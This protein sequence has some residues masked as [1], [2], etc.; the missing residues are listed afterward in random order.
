MSTV[1]V[2][3]KNLELSFTHDRNCASRGISTETLIRKAVEKYKIVKD[4]NFTVWTGDV[5]NPDFFS[6][7]VKEDSYDR[8]FPCFI[9]D[10]FSE[11]GMG[12]YDQTIQSFV[13]TIPLTNKIGW[14][15]AVN[16]T[17]RQIY[18]D[19]FKDTV[20]SE[21]VCN[22]WNRINPR[23]LT[24]HT[25]TY[26]SYQDQIDRWKYLLDMEGCGYSGRTKVLLNTPR[27]VF[28][29][30][31]PH[32]EWWHQYIKPWVH[33]VP[34]KRDLSDLEENY[35]RIESDEKL[36]QHIKHNQSEFAKQFL[37]RDSALLRIK[38]IIDA[39]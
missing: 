9:Y 11:T 26:L 33:Y 39:L 15:G 16:C 5:Y 14:I 10:K 6:V 36:Q 18:L 37:V 21:A 34:V 29:A 28:I 35:H 4:F 12:D 17:A 13:A 38:D 3:Q 27:I 2:T 25:P 1:S 8:G 19:K 22:Q 24:Q 20:F 30:D 32:K 31:R 23:D 7:C